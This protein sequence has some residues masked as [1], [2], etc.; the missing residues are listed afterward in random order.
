[1]HYCMF[2]FKPENNKCIA[3]ALVFNSILYCLHTQEAKS[4]L[5]FCRNWYERVSAAQ[6]TSCRIRGPQDKVCNGR[7]IKSSVFVMMASGG[8]GG[9]A[10]ENYDTYAR[11]QQRLGEGHWSQKGMFF[12]QIGPIFTYRGYL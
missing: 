8:G 12:N 3:V 9:I 2:Y 10:I 1:M 6:T 5:L 4:V 7:L 11:T